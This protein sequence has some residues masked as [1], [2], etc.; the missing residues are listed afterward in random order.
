MS[1]L[2]QCS[3]FM[4]AVMFVGLQADAAAV[5]PNA[6]DTNFDPTLQEVWAALQ[7][8]QQQITSQVD[9]NNQQQRQLESQDATIKRQEVKIAMLEAAAG[10]SHA[11][12]RYAPPR[13]AGTVVAPATS[14]RH[15]KQDTV[16]DA[17]S[18]PERLS[19]VTT[20]CCS[21]EG[22]DEEEHESV[23]P[24][25]I[26]FDG[27]EDGTVNVNDLMGVLG[28]YGCSCDGCGGV[29]ASYSEAQQFPPVEEN[30][31]QLPEICG[32]TECA[33][34]F[35]N[36]YDDC[37]DQIEASSLPKAQL[38]EFYGTCEVGSESG[39][40]EAQM[41]TQHARIPRTHFIALPANEEQEAQFEEMFPL[42]GPL[43]ASGEPVQEVELLEADTET[44]SEVI[45]TVAELQAVCTD[46]NLRTCAP[47]CDG[48]KFGD[49]LSVMVSR[50]T[51]L[52][53]C[54]LKR[55]VMSWVAVGG[56]GGTI[57][58]DPSTAS[59]ELNSQ[60]PGPFHLEVS[61]P[62]TMLVTMVASTGQ[63]IIVLGEDS[64]ATAVP[65]VVDRSV[66]GFV[67]KPLG[68]VE[69]TYLAVRTTT[70]AAAV[71][72]NLDAQA[73]INRCSFELGGS[74]VVLSG[75]M[76]IIDRSSFTETCSLCNAISITGS[77]QMRAV[78]RVIT[79]DPTLTSR[80]GDPCE[81]PTGWMTIDGMA[82]ENDR[83][84]LAQVGRGGRA[85]LGLG[86]P[87][88]PA[89]DGRLRHLR[90]RTD[91]PARLPQPELPRRQRP[92]PDHRHRAV[93]PG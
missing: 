66:P 23:A 10:K 84:T 70:T 20:A 80:K 50:S 17:D 52:M 3:L 29:P 19:Q 69:V 56:E 9:V 4:T 43:P 48:E 12:G 41:F 34:V 13:G 77:I 46:H 79:P 26:R 55:S 65:W 5:L 88:A 83:T 14:K 64:V 54:A 91:R 8:Q 24:C 16:C 68:S 59:Q 62:T 31:C 89:R 21:G 7:Q 40:L 49:F 30:F 1:Y 45:Q 42:I 15:R 72:V 47:D 57:T 39:A 18:W 53:I 82:V 78:P 32:N 35:T 22:Q 76:A 74:G 28:A 73:L 71:E 60:A 67:A 38:Q 37:A 44:G 90:L 86:R 63:R 87:A 27:D 51:H 93:G 11:Q 6:T 58:T 2:W 92:R 25:F 81:I 85:D 61:E 33:T 36:F 75:G